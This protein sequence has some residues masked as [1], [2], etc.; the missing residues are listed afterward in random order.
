[1]LQFRI[2]QQ[3]AGTHDAQRCGCGGGKKDVLRARSSAAATYG[4]AR[5]ADERMA[6]NLIQRNGGTDVGGKGTEKQ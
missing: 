5:P 6:T 2:G 1:M 3:P 4:S